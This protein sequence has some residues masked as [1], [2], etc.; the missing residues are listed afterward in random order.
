MLRDDIVA[1]FARNDRPHGQELVMV[2]QHFL[3]AHPEA[4]PNGARSP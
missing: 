1:A 4:L 2:L 3:S